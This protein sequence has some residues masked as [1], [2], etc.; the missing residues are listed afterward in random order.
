MGLHIERKYCTGQKH[1]ARFEVF[2]ISI[3]K[4]HSHDKNYNEVE[5]SRMNPTKMQRAWRKG[6]PGSLRL[7]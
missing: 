4:A 2:W 5:R 6:T 7:Y 1:T 3:S